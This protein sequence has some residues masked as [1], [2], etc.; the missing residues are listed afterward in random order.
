M[1]S[2]KKLRLTIINIIIVVCFILAIIFS[3]INKEIS[4][5]FLTSSIIA[6]ILNILLKKLWV[7]IKQMKKNYD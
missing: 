4:F 7:K 1:N 2:K 6:T 5:I 3:F